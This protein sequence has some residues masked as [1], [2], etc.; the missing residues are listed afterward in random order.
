MNEIY[1]QIALELIKRGYE[2]SKIVDVI[3]YLES[4]K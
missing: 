3:K 2:L 4:R 1:N